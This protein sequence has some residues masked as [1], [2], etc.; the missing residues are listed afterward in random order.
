LLPRRRQHGFVV[1]PATLLRWH[2]QLVRR[3]W[4][5][6]QRRPGRPPT[7][8]ALLRE[9]VRRLTR[10]NRRWGYQRIAGELIK[11]GFRLG[12]GSLVHDRDSKF[13]ASFDECSAAKASASSPH[14]CALP[15]RTPTPRGSSAPSENESLD[16]LLTLGRRHLERVLHVYT[17]HYNSE[18]PHRGLALRPS[19]PPQLK[20]PARGAVQRRDRLGGLLH[21]YYRAAA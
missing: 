11:P 21:E 17:A 10:E 1:T 7:D 6:P 16:W 9:L 4:T 2:R 19:D 13:T 12:C 14:P 20:P 3:N 18:R 15:E 8:R 5:Y